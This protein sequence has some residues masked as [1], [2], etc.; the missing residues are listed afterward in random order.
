MCVLGEST[1]GSVNS[2]TANNIK[3]SH[4]GDAGLN[5]GLVG[6]YHGKVGLSDGD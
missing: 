1:H 5:D 2:A 4:L 6:E 3:Y